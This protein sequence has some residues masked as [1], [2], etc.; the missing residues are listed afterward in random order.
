VQLAPGNDV[1]PSADDERDGGV[2]RRG[3]LEATEK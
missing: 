3:A 1:L 2:A